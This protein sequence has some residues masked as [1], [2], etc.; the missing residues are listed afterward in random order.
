MTDEGSRFRALF[1]HSPDAIYLCDDRGVIADANPRATEYL[2]YRHEELVGTPIWELASGDPE[3]VRARWDALDVGGTA[4]FEAEHTAA[5]GTTVPV[6][7]HV[8]RVDLDEAVDFVVIVRDVTEQRAREAELERHA[9][10]LELYALAFPDLAFILDADGRYLDVLVGQHSE[11]LL[12]DDVDALV[13]SSSRDYFPDET[14]DRAVEVIRTAIETGELQHFEYAAEV[15]GEAH[16]FEAH[17]EAL[18][19]PVAGEEAVVW[20][21]RDV[22]DRK[23]REAELQAIRDRMEFALDSTDSI[24]YD[25][26]VETEVERRHGPFERLFGMP[27]AEV[28]TSEAFYER[29]VHPEDR[30]RLRARQQ[31]V[32]DG[33][34][35]SATVEYRT[36]PDAGRVRWVRTV[37]T[38]TDDPGDAA[39][40]IGLDTDITDRKRRE[41]ELERQNERLEEFASVVSHD[42]RNPLTVA[43]GRLELA[44]EDHDSEDLA[45]VARAHDRIERLIDDLLWLAREGR[46]VGELEPVDLAAAAEDA[47]AMVADGGADLGVEDGLT[48]VLAD[49]DRLHQLLENLFRNAVQHAGEDVRIT[50]GGHED[51]FYVE[52]DGE[53]IPPDER[54]RVFQAGFT[55]GESGTGFGLAIVRQIAEGHGWAVRAT[56]GSAG[57]A[58]FEFS[59]VAFA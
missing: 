9:D 21:A 2:D 12:V 4:W 29:A 20:V 22:T 46:D 47:W 8:S 14:A 11:E 6:R 48:P 33:R 49:R 18:P 38:R 13:G 32:M 51:G 25:I 26:D 10:R 44:R 34:E 56:E 40:I 57:G 17:I 53:G 3:S 31:A 42:L 27:S 1:E 19:F 39:R 16:W 36:H 41:A 7:V 15:D 58:R 5:D 59:D 45:A 52:D 43:R 30:D 50:V 54:D 55:T 23:T 37:M 24:I 28:D 35:A